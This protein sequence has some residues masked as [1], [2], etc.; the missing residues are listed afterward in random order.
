MSR[1]VLQELPIACGILGVMDHQEL[2][3]FATAQARTAGQIMREYFDR[4]DKGTHAKHDRTPVTEADTRINHDLIAAVVAAYPSHG[5]QGE[6]ESLHVERE[7]RWICDPIDGT[8]AFIMGI[9]TAMFSLAFVDAG[10]PKVAVMYDPFQ[11]RLLSAIYGRGAFMNG[12]RLHVSTTPQMSGA[13]L[14]AG[15][16]LEAG[17]HRLHEELV[18]RGARV[19]AIPGTVYKG[20]MVARGLLE[21]FAL[22]GS[23]HDFAAL[24]LIVQEAGGKVTGLSGESLR[25]DQPFGRGAI[26]SNGQVHAELVDAMST[27]DIDAFVSRKNEGES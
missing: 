18:R 8:G 16:T 10:L 20:A 1:Y 11:D 12:Q 27:I 5:V 25:Y 21:G 4:T 23:A 19:K 26:V 7:Q 14:G 24:Q 17:A 9:P 6:E 22:G 3:V 13:W 15:G 2:L